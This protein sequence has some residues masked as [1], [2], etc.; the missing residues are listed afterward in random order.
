VAYHKD[1]RDY[2]RTLDKCGLLVT[3]KNPVNKDTQLHSLVRLQFRGLPEEQR[4]GFL[5]ENVID[6]RG[7]RYK[8]PVTVGIIAGSRS[9]YALGMGC[10]PEEISSRWEKA[11]LHP[12]K[13]VEVTGAPLYEEIHEGNNLLEHAGIGEFPIPISTPGYDIAPF[14]TAPYWITKDPETG[15]RN[16][17]TY[18][19]QVKSPT[20]TGIMLHH[21]HQNLAIHWNKCRKLGIPLQAA[22]VIGG[23]PNIGYVSV[24][25][26]PYE[27]DELDVAG[28]IAGEPVKLVK[29]RTVDLEVPAYAEI[30]FEG[31]ISTT[32]MEPEAPFGEATGYMGQRETMP[33]FTIK[34]I[35]HRKNAMWQSF[36]SQFPPSESSKLRQIGR[37]ANIFKIVKHDLKI[38]SVKAVAIHESTGSSGLTVIQMDNPERHHIWQALETAAVNINNGKICVAVDKDID[39]WDPDAVNWAV[40]LR[41]NSKRDCRF[42]SQPGGNMDVSLAPPGAME[43]KDARFEK[44]PQ[45]SRLLIDA[46][47]KWPYPPVSLP[48][49]EFMEDA[50]KLWKQENLP[51]LELKEPWYGYDLGFWSKEYEE[52]ADLAVKGDYYRTGEFLASKRKKVD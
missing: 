20:C 47:M 7:K 42:F 31:E 40:W 27:V 29:C 17:G 4:K 6:S 25:N 39:P 50:L 26:L 2:I 12:I 23:S 33:F 3:I 15:L 49:K 41:M 22:I 5:F 16:V 21:Q 43:K 45:S 35:A 19:A 34:C 46:T 13:P 10:K 28:G 51:P 1:L 8:N 36:I 18:R 24:T 37:E 11:Q 38:A 52:Q 44:M 32:E 9:I 14:M 30:V 48:K